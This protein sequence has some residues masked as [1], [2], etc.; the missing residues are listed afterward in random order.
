MESIR[1]SVRA[2][3]RSDRMFMAHD[4]EFAATKDA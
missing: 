3:N 4:N 2:E 1:I